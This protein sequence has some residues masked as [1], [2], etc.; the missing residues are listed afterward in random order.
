[1]GLI[2][3]YRP[4]ISP[5]VLDGGT[6]FFPIL[7]ERLNLELVETQIFGS[8]VVYLRY[9]CVTQGAGARC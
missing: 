2:D 6:P 7:E 5:V 1:M 8:C 3:E 9:R 4:F